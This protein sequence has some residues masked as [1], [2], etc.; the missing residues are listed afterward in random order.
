MESYYPGASVGYRKVTVRSIAPEKADMGDDNTANNSNVLKYNAA[1]ISIYEFFTPKEFPVWFDQTDMTADPSIVRIALIPGIYTGFAKRKARSQGYAVVLND[2]AGKMRA[3]EQRTRP[4][5]TNPAGT[6]ITRQEYIYNT[7]KPFSDLYPNYLSSK[8]Q[9]LTGEGMYQTASLGQTHDIIIDMKEDR[10]KSVSGGL[11]A[12]IDVNG[13]VPVPTFFP[14]ANVRDLS[15]RTV[16]VNKVIYRTGILKAV[17]ATHESSTIRTD[18][19]AFDP[20]TGGALITRTTNEY[21]DP[22]FSFSYPGHWYYE[23]LKGGYLNHDVVVDNI[24]ASGN[25]LTNLTAATNGRVNIPAAYLAA[26]KATKD[27]FAVGDE[28]YVLPGGGRYHVMKTGPGFIDLVT[29]AGLHIPAATQI[30]SMRVIRSGHDNLQTV[31]AGALAMRTINGIQQFNPQTMTAIISN[32]AYTIPATQNI[33]SASA[34]EFVD[35]MQLFCTSGCETGNVGSGSTVDPY[36][37]GLR[38]NW[39]PY[40]SYAFVTDRNQNDNIRQDGTY[41]AFVPFNWSNP[42]LA[43]ARWTSAATITKYSP[44]GFELENKDA[45]GNY[46]SALYGYKNA[47]N[48]AVA[49]N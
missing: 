30:S 1:P 49:A 18:N 42:S 31:S 46:T 11:E 23:A 48:T 28:V 43:D 32:T 34:V 12:N 25:T 5:A 35:I 44:Y 36:I 17:I 29:F 22:V 21:K 7:E 3:V 39:R 8:V 13:P 10:M 24:D 14:Q 41:T 37:N 19:I 47:L 2:M 6:L 16:V 33:L 45:T 9:V 38:G 40:R 26:G 15:M 27:Y 4:T 20:E